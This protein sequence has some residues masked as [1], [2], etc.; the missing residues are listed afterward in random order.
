M[1]G[2]QSIREMA[3]REGDDAEG[4]AEELFP[5]GVLD[6]DELDLKAL[7]A[8]GGGKI[9]VTV[10]I[11]AKEF[12]APRGGLLDPERDHTVLLTTRWSKPDLVPDWENTQPGEPR[13]MDG[14]KVR[15]VLE[16]IYVERIEGE[17]GIIEA[18]FVE[19]LK[20]DPAR[21]GALLERLNGRAADALK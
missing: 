17:E 9:Q 12:P 6:G 7:I 21:A 20:A 2:S 4:A 14:W 1:E 16:P 10:S 15:Q 19:F 11:R 5:N 13:K 3:E 18:N 8:K